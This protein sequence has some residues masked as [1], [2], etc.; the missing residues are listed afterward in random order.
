MFEGV[1][2]VR[3][4]HF[5]K[6]LEMVP[7]LPCLALEVSLGSRDILFIG[8]IRFL[9]VVVATSCECDPPGMPLLPLLAAL[10]AFLCVFDGGLGRCGMATTRGCFPV[11]QNEGSPNCFLARCVPGSDIKQLLGGVRLITIELMHQGTS[12][13]IRL[14]RRDDVGRS[15][16]CNLGG[17][18]PT[19]VGNSLG[20]R[21]CQ[22][23]H[24]CPGN[25]R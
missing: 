2:M 22:V 20:P 13:H 7:R 12:H 14:E 18:H 1:R 16:E 21:G 6:F 24:M 3:T 10:S 19:F 25:C 23:A 5:E 8:V 9:V 4:G 15:A 17:I 11:A